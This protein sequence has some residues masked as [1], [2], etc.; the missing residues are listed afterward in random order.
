[1]A[2]FNSCVSLPEGNILVGLFSISSEGLLY[3]RSVELIQSSGFL[4]DVLG[5]S[6]HPA[7][8]SHLHLRVYIYIYIFI[9]FH[10]YKVLFCAIYVCFSE[11][12]RVNTY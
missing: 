4:Q 3:L 9:R 5:K 10:K 8:S 6:T 2:I 12:R 7:Y 11:R 1:M